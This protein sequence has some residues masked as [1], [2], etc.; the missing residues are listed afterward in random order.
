MDTLRRLQTIPLADFM[1]NFFKQEEY[2]ANYTYLEAKLQN[3]C[4]SQCNVFKDYIVNQVD[5]SSSKDEAQGVMEEECVI[6]S[7]QEVFAH[8]YDVFM[9]ELL[10][11]KTFYEDGFS[12]FQKAF[13]EQFAIDPIDF[14]Y[15][16][17]TKDSWQKKYN[18]N[19]N[20][21]GLTTFKLF[22]VFKSLQSIKAQMKE[23]ILPKIE[24]CFEKMSTSY[25][26][27]LKLVYSELD[28]Q[29]NVVKQKFV[30]EY[31]KIIQRRIKEEKAKEI[32]LL[33]EIQQLETSAKNVGAISESVTQMK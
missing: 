31:D 3:T 29:M 19:F 27:R 2:S 17:K 8:C 25:L 13:K 9:E 1:V 4:R 20:K 10:E 23:V 18:L 21:E 24:N 16:L 14:V 30:K 11:L 33:A 6:Q 15:S 22:R 12:E 32:Q 5:M 26:K 28:K 7:G